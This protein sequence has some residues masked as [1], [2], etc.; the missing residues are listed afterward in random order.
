MV[1]WWARDVTVGLVGQWQSVTCVPH[2]EP[3]HAI[4]NDVLC[5]P[6]MDDQTIHKQMA[7]LIG[8]SAWDAHLSCQNG[9]GYQLRLGA[10]WKIPWPITVLELFEPL[11][12][13]SFM[14][15]A[16][17]SDAGPRV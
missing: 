1:E 17:S 8:P 13:G 7:G 14:L 16:G 5:G 12:E 10:I 4:N 11:G 9:Y 15:G 2:W 3:N 6:A